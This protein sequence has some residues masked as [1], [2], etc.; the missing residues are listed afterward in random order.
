[1]TTGFKIFVLINKHILLF[2][3]KGRAIVVK[4]VKTVFYGCEVVFYKNLKDKIF[5]IESSNGFLNR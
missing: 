1:M 2:F 5:D 3:L 4:M